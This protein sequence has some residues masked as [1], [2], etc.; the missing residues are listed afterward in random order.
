[1]KIP[2]PWKPFISDE[3]DVRNIHKD[4]TAEPVPASVL[5]NSVGWSLPCALS[6]AFLCV[7]V[8]ASC[9]CVCV[10]VSLTRVWRVLFWHF[11]CAAQ[12]QVE[13]LSFKV[14]GA[15]DGFSYT[16]ATGMSQK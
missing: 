1:M 2:P 12:L 5:Q 3:L 10:C 13:V 7:C 9:V 4:F 14:D 8:C 16:G 15:F 6:S 11:P